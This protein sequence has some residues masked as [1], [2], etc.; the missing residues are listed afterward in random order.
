LA[1]AV[2]IHIEA[3]INGAHPVAQLL[4]L[5]GV[6]MASH[7]AGDVLETGLPQHGVVEQSLHEDHFRVSPD[8]LPGVQATLGTG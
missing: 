2:G 8:L 7:R 3:E 6:E 4:K 5:A 1:A